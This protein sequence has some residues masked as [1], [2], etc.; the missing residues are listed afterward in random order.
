MAIG[1]PIIASNVGGLKEI[2]SN[3]DIGILV[4]EKD[5]KSIA[6][7]VIQLITEPEYRNNLS[8]NARE[9]VCQNLSWPQIAKKTLSI[10]SDIHKS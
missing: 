7:A 2:M 3:R 5:V 1:K 8:R 9:Y 6:R 10:Y 4:E